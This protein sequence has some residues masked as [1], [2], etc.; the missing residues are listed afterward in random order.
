MRSIPINLSG[1]SGEYFVVAELSRRGFIASLTLKNT[2]GIDILV[3]TV[4]VKK[5]YAVQVKTTQGKK[6][7]WMLN[8]KSE[9][10]I[11]KNFFYIF[12]RVKSDNE[13]PVFHIVPS[14]IVAKHI[15]EDHQKWLNTIGK[16]GQKRN[17]SKMRK[18]RDY[19]DKYLE[20]WEILK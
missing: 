19:D 10:L 16:K 15:K 17:D 14:K 13:L 8:E 6:K 7:E 20:K 12:V 9:K 5:S 3:S 1:I 18:F 2:Q 11:D 4:E